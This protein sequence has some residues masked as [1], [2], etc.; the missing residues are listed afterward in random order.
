MG[1]IRNLV[2]WTA[3]VHQEEPLRHMKLSEELIK[4]MKTI[5]LS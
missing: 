3:M 5:K 4:Y 2:G 1:T